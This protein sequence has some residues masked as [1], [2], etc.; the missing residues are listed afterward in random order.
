MKLALITGISG[1]DGSYLS[2][3]LLNKNYKIYGLV[4]RNSLLHIYKRF[5]KIKDKINIHYSDLLD[6]S[7]I[8]SIINNIINDNIDYTVLEI[9]NLAAQS[10]VKISFDISEYTCMVNS[11]GT[12]KLLECIKNFREED[13][14]KVKFYQAGSS[15]MFGKFLEIPQ[16]EKTPFNPQSPY[17]CSKVFSH[18]IVNNYKDAYN[19][20]ACNGILFNHESPRRGYNFVTM[21][22]ILGIKKILNGEMEYITLGNINSK[23]D[24]GHAEDYVKGMWLMLQQKKPDNYILATE[25]TYSVREFI[26]KSFKY[27]NYNITWSGEGLNEIG[28]DQNGIIRIKIDKKYY[29]PTEV[30][31]LLGDATKAKKILKWERK[32]DTIEKIIKDMILNY[33]K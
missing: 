33:N 8:N 32:Y 28:K 20:Y 10:H 15:E 6:S 23:R 26:E 18:H 7:S 27:F 29:R 14:K 1:Q 9:Y 13:I 11:I 4:R 21:K 19:I 17:A 24:W 31:C 2:E 16:N 25:T 3:L 5:D 12:L 22:I 30:D